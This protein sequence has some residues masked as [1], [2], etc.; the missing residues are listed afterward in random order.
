[1]PLLLR[2]IDHK[3]K[4]A[5]DGEA[6]KYLLSDQAP[7]D[8]LQDLRTE[9]NRLSLWRIEDNKSNLSRVLAAIVS[10]REHLQKMDYILIDFRHI[11][12][13]GLRFEQE[14]GDTL[15]KEA[16]SW[17]ID[18]IQLSALDIA[19]LA[20]LLFVN[21]E[22]VR[23]LEPELIEV[24]R[25]SVKAGHIREAELKRTVAQKLRG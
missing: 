18:V 16:N 21:G 15:D 1:M 17:H 19:R 3:V 2:K 5:K 8:V 11:Q 24:L 4:W 22:R 23:Q 14:A 7:A 25:Q 6:L 9:D 10:T 12:E 13:N 20:N